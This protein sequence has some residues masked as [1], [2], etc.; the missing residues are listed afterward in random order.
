MGG[1]DVARTEK[2]KK[3]A[4]GVEIKSGVGPVCLFSGTLFNFTPTSL[5]VGRCYDESRSHMSDHPREATLVET[6][7]K[8]PQERVQAAHKTL[9]G[10]RTIT[11]TYCDGLQITACIYFYDSPRSGSSLNASLALL[12]MRII[13]MNPK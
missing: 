2:R 8:H 3:A 7:Q 10:S 9:S 5:F 4:A 12:M 6:L 11:V 1:K 13:T